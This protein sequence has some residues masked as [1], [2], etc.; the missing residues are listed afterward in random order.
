MQENTANA[1]G[2]AHLWASGDLVS[3]SVACILAIMSIASWY[4]IL[5]KAWDWFRVRRAE[6]TY[7][8][9]NWLLFSLFCG[10]PCQAKGYFRYFWHRC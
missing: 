8:Q 7:W 5:A 3:H 9:I 2:F 1:L 6:T 10:R 4:L